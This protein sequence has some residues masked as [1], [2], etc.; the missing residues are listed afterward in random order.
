MVSLALLRE[1]KTDTKGREVE[2]RVLFIPAQIQELSSLKQVELFVEKEAGARI[3]F[4]DNAYE[5]AGAAIISHQEALAKDIV[6][7]VKETRLA[8][9]DGLRN[10][11]WISYQHFAQ[12]KPRTEA[13][14]QASKKLGT[15]FLAL[16]TME[17][18]KDGRSFFPCLAPMSEA[19][20][21]IIARHADEYA[22]LKKKIITSG[23]PGTGLCGVKTAILGGGNVGRTAAEEFSERGCEVF[24][25]EK[26]PERAKELTEYFS[27]NSIR[28]PKVRV[29]ELTPENLRNSV[30]EALFL[31]SS[32]YTAGKKPEKLIT[33]DL[34]K[35]M[36]PGGCVYPVDIDQGGG[37]EGVIETSI[38]EP[39]A[40]PVIPGTEV[41][42]FAPPN[43]PSL[44]AKTTSE[45]LGAALLPYLEAIITKGLKKAAEEDPT[46]ASGI[47]IQQGKI[48][49]PGLAS[50]FPTLK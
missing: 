18:K 49:H 26:T 43:L 19:A 27:A 23:L 5:K 44:G 33:V 50:V 48:I 11:L 3:D 35:T 45:A 32:M 29:V 10:N 40:L 7:G 28:F 13:A 8:D 20:A 12:S 24:L 21:K 47:N 2:N 37:V 9:M 25:L 1:S 6:L 30:R 39:F 31:V 46:I 22:L 34:L 41:F 4:G 14:L 38:L 42:F 17:L 16:E 36:T 15:T